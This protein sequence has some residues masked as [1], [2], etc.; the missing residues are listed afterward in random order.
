MDAARD[1]GG[2]SLRN[3]KPSADTEAAVREVMI[4]AGVTPPATV[5]A[6]TQQIY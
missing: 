4:A 5:V 1:L 3:F 2:I 6:K